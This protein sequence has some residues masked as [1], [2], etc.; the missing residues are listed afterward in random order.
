VK[1]DAALQQ[2]AEVPGEEV[3]EGLAQVVCARFETGVQME[4]TSVYGLFSDPALNFLWGRWEGQHECIARLLSEAREEMRLLGA[5]REQL[6]QPDYGMMSVP[7]LL[8]VANVSN[9]RRIEKILLSRLHRSDAHL[10]T[11]AFDDDNP[12]AWRIAFSCL[13]ALKQHQRF[14]MP[15]LDKLTS[16]VVSPPFVEFRAPKI[17]AVSTIIVQLPPEM[18]LPFG[19][20]WFDSSVWQVQFVGRHILEQ[21]A[22]TE[23]VDQLTAFISRELRREN[24]DEVD[25]YGLCSALDAL[26]HLLNIGQLP[27]VEAAYAQSVYSFARMRAAKAMSHNGPEWFSRTYAYECTWDCEEETRVL[28]CETVSL[29]RPG[30]RER[31]EEIMSDPLEEEPVKQAAARRFRAK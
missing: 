7:E 14:Y 19:R 21:Y 10:Y 20:Q 18:T 9:H 31:V 27:E 29:A 8:R 11:A 26:S 15:V 3:T 22:T 30:A 25:V 28:G 24:P 12:L 13:T 6:A 17:S 1:R 5:R 23:D 16:Y 2:L 4:A